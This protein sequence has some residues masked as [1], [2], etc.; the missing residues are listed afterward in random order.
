MIEAAAGSGPASENLQGRKPRDGVG[1]RL[2]RRY[3]DLLPRVMRV[4]EYGTMQGVVRR[5][6]G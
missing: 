1:G 3:G 4:I 2:V 6:P 5:G